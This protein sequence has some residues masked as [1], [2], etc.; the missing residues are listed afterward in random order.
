MKRVRFIINPISGTVSKSAIPEAI[1]AYLDK[2]KFSYEILETQ[3]AGH[4]EELSRKAAEEHIDVVV[5]IGGD[6][7][8]N[9]VARGITHSS[10]ALGIIPC[11]S[12]QRTGTPPTYTY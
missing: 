4:A 5:A 2:S 3:Y 8:V 1:D 6:G 9:E 12:R 11:G 10:T 7:T